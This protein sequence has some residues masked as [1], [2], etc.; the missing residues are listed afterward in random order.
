MEE[1][2]RCLAVGPGVFVVKNTFPNV[3]I[4]QR[5]TEALEAII[6]DEKATGGSKGDHFAPGGANERIWNSYQKHAVKDP[7]NFIDYYSNPVL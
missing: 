2:Y 3:T 1:M 7:K 4:L 6:Q 5:S